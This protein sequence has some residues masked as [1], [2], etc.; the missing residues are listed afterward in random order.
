MCPLRSEQ[1]E[2]LNHFLEDVDEQIAYK[3][4]HAAVNEELRAHVEDK[5]ET[6]MEYGIEEDEAYE[7]AIRDMGDASVIG[8]QMNETHHLRI[9]KPLLAAI[10]ILTALAAAGNRQQYGGFGGS[11]NIC[12]LWG[13]LVLVFSM[14]YGYPL[15]LKH[16][17][18]LTV[19]FTALGGFYMLIHSEAGRRLFEDVMISSPVMLFNPCRI[20]SPTVIFLIFQTAVPVMAV[21]L[22]HGRHRWLTALSATGAFLVFLLW[23]NSSQFVLK[24]YIYTSVLALLVSGL[25][26]M[27]YMVGKGYAEYKMQYQ[28]ADFS[29]FLDD[30]VPQSYGKNYWIFRWFMKYGRI[31][32]GILLLAVFSMYGL[33]FAT[34]FQIRNRLGRLAALGGSLALSV[35]GLLYVLGNFGHRFGMFGNLPF[36]SEGFVSITGSAV[37][38]GLVLS[39]YRFDTVVTEKK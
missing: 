23:V 19:L 5:A 21:L 36:V 3:P 27:L 12:I 14:R 22:Y 6:Y 9:A 38:A 25:G 26:M 35:Q 2:R 11:E 34:A 15:L 39:A 18:K 24:T 37:L 33:L 8:I 30:V 7:K 29:I 31:P 32:A 10:L 16:A 17:G 28:E 13:L 20:F 4:I 1:Q